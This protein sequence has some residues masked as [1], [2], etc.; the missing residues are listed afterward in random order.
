MKHLG[1]VI[2]ALC[3]C[4]SAWLYF[5]N[6]FGT[7][8]RDPRARLLGFK[9]YTFSSKSMLPTIQPG[10]FLFVSTFS[11]GFASP[12]RGDLIAFFPPDGDDKSYVMRVLAEGGESIAITDGA[13]L[14]SGKPV[15]EVY[16]FKELV[17]APYSVHMET[18]V[19]P[20]GY[21]F[22]LGDNRDNARDSRFFGALPR[23]RVIGKVVT[24]PD[25]S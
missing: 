5:E 13:V 22:V 4:V 12:R 16:L 9:T 2:I 10:D 23:S 7:A 8:S 19:V 15:K 6:P 17:T 14:I 20:E 18:Q 11:Y 1:L 3:A 21:V 25:S 24:Q